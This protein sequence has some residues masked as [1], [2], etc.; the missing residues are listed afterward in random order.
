MQVHIVSLSICKEKYPVSWQDYVVQ[1][2]DRT[3]VVTIL[4][5]DDFMEVSTKFRKCDGLVD[6]W[7]IRKYL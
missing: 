2:F 6:C 1:R 3:R 7:K 5:W 4:K